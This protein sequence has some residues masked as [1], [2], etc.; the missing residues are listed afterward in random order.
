MHYFKWKIAHEIY[1][2]TDDGDIYDSLANDSREFLSQSHHIAELTGCVIH[3]HY[4]ISSVSW[5]CM[6]PVTYILMSAPSTVSSYSLYLSP[7]SVWLIFSQE[8]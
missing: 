5:A 2:W 1:L 7:S 3:T 4:N 6:T 8:N